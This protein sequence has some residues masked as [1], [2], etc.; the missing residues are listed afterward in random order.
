MC[1]FDVFT[2]LLRQDV[3]MSTGFTRRTLPLKT[4]RPADDQQRRRRRKRILLIVGIFVALV[5]IGAVLAI[6]LPVGSAKPS[7]TAPRS[8]PSSQPSASTPPR[9]VAFDPNVNAVLP[10]HRVVAF[11]AVP[12]APATGPAYHLSASMLSRLRAQGAAYQKLDPAHPVALGIDLVV[13]VPDRF[14]GKSGTYSHYVDDATVAQYAAFCKKNDLL[15]FLD[16]NFGWA[17]PITVLDHFD[18][19][20]K[21]P[22]VDVAVDPEWMFPRHNGVPGVNLSNVRASDLNPLIEAVAAMPLKYHVPRKIMI[23]HQFRG[24]GDGKSNP[25]S[26]GSSE[27]ADKK[28]LVNDPR[29]DLVIHI[30]SVGG[31]PGD[32][33]V[34]ETQY[35]KWVS[36][37]MK[38]YDNFKY[39]GCKIFYKLEARH[40]LMTPKQVMSM[41]PAPMVVTY[42]N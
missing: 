9:P 40:K 26:A 1:V 15:L 23:I 37:D 31:W 35:T 30:D 34:K 28:D 42:G 12:N 4:A 14:R 19:Y 25:H 10:T 17:K 6:W 32:I 22:F 41:K 7:A 18:K 21:L 16:L 29:V 38:K 8:G 2:A 3:P 20:L 11:Y 13:D 39:G 5:A 33:G 24:D 27:I 36:T